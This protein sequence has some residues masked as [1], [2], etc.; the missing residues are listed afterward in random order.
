[1]FNHIKTT[2]ISNEGSLFYLDCLKT[3][4]NLLYYTPF[5]VLLRLDWYLFLSLLTVILVVSTYDCIIMLLY[6][7]GVG[8]NCSELGYNKEGNLCIHV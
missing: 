3:T 8:Y 4:H 7:F 1:M 2:F 5:V 6:I